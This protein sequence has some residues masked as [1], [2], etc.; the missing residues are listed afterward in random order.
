MQCPG[1]KVEKF[2]YYNNFLLIIRFQPNMYQVINDEPILLNKQNLTPDLNNIYIDGLPI[3]KNPSFPDPSQINNDIQDKLNLIQNKV[4]EIIDTINKIQNGD[5][6]VNTE[7]PTYEDLLD[8]L[9][10]IK[11]GEDPKFVEPT[12]VDLEN[13]DTENDPDNLSDKAPIS[14][15]DIDDFAKLIDELNIPEWENL[16][17]I[18]QD[19]DSVICSIPDNIVKMQLTYVKSE[20]PNQLDISQNPDLNFDSALDTIKKAFENTTGTELTDKNSLNDYYQNLISQNKKDIPKTNIEDYLGIPLA[21]L[22]K[23][24][25]IYLQILDKKP[26]VNIYNLNGD[27]LQINKE[28]DLLNPSVIAFKTDGFNHELYYISE[29]ENQLY[30]NKMTIPKDLGI[31]TIGIDIDAQ[32]PYCGLIFDIRILTARESLVDDYLNNSYLFTF[33]TGALAFYDWHKDRI[34]YNLVFPLPDLQKPVKMFGM[35]NQNR[36][37]IDT[38]KNPYHFMK[39]TFITE[40]FC[41]NNVLE[42]KDFSLMFWFNVESDCKINNG[43]GFSDFRCIIEDRKYGT[44]LYYD[45]YLKIFKLEYIDE[46]QNKIEKYFHY[47]LTKDT[48]YF[49]NFKY[50]KDENKL[51]FNIRDI[52]TGAKSEIIW[53]DVKLRNFALTSM[54]TEF[55]NNKYTNFFDCKFGTLAI[56][57]SFLLDEREDFYF[58]DQKI[59]IKMLKL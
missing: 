10:Q 4:D 19:N 37:F 46:N 13:Y 41:P 8:A 28:I 52:E 39:H 15:C 31:Y 5:D 32:K 40:F 35:N 48:W 18:P 38:T 36:Y 21:C 30:S 26:T 53:E 3:I 24:E 59:V 50:K 14:Y 23:D 34:Y 57:D 20:I 49:C 1:I 27:I 11:A 58:N 2:T 42:N 54:L 55:K 56:F 44:K 45:D 51:Y 22:N 17:D 47:Y 33:P 16:N 43:L 6:L 12:S 25:K 7:C 9:E 29:K